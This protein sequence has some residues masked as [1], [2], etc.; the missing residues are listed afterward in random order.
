MTPTMARKTKPAQPIR[1]DGPAVETLLHRWDRP[2]TD[3]DMRPITGTVACRIWTPLD[4]YYDEG[5]LEGGIYT[6]DQRVDAGR[7]YTKLWDQAQPCGRDSTDALNGKGGQGSGL[8]LGHSQRVAEAA[9]AAVDKHMPP[10]DLIIIR[11]V[12]GDRWLPSQAVRLACDG[13]F[14][15]TVSGAFRLAL[16]SLILAFEAAAREAREKQKRVGGGA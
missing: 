8:P 1:A 14:K 6:A 7:R 16:N 15:D 13:E 11:R 3:N 12:L 10:R 2:A 5:K 9:L 4:V